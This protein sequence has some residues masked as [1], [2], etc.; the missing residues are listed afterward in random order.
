MFTLKAASKAD[1]DGI[2][3]VEKESFAP[4]I[5][6]LRE[7]FLQR[8]T[9]FSEGFIVF[10]HDATRRAAGYMC[11]ELW[12]AET[13]ETE[14]FSVG[15]DIRRFHRAEGSALYISSFALLKEFR[16]K[17]NGARLFHAALHHFTQKLTVKNAVL[18]VREDWK[19]ARAI[20][21]KAG[22]QTYAVFDK[23]FPVD[24]GGDGGFKRGLLM[25]ADVRSITAFK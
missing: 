4:E 5:Q 22:F 9:V 3:R 21:E 17:G 12:D 14:R 13:A 20:Y 25:K 15:H 23:A 8:L 6:E 11:T 7:T 1:I 10:E 16:G 24:R 19:N 18:M 2:M